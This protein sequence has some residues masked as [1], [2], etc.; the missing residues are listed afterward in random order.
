M[1]SFVEFVMVRAITLLVYCVVGTYVGH[2]VVAM[3]LALAARFREVVE[4]T[5]EGR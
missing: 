2:N 3:H 5:C 4:Q 1:E